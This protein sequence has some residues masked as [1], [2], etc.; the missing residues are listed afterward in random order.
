MVD[1]SSCIRIDGRDFVFS[2]GEGKF[3]T[4][5]LSDFGSAPFLQVLHLRG[6][7][8]WLS[9]DRLSVRLRLLMFVIRGIPVATYLKAEDNRS[10]LLHGEA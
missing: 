1:P 6:T 2:V 10:D 7:P 3:N 4:G 9:C 8:L 5:C